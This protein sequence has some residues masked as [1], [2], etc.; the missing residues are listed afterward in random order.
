MILFITNLLEFMSI[1]EIY[2][3]MVQFL[4]QVLNLSLS[5]LKFKLK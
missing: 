2:S 3:I 5:Y 4:T 1:K